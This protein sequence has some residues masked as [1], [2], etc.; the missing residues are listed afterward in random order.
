MNSITKKALYSASLVFIILLLD[1]LSKIWVKSS[2]ELYEELYI[3]SWF[4]LLFVENDGMAF[5]IEWGDKIYLTLFRIVASLGIATYLGYC[6]MKNETWTLLTCISLVLAGAS[7]NIIDCVFY[8]KWFDYAP[9][10]YGKV[11]DMLYF[12]LIEGH[13]WN[14]IPMVGGE[15]FIFFS[16]IFNIADSAICI[17][18]FLLLI[19]EKRLYK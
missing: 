1:Q 11:V 15:H 6:V 18:I 16:P 17:G 3:F 13:F 8:G 4:R 19:F 12:P 7:G 5:G 14:W 9:Y 10:F 2:F